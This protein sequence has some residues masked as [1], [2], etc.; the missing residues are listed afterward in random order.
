VS[1]L[2]K[3]EQFSA[4]MLP[5]INELNMHVDGKR[6]MELLNQGQSLYA[7]DSPDGARL[8]S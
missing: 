1:R 6:F 2:A 5:P 3:A 4:S 7:K 8:L